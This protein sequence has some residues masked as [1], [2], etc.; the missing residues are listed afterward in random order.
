FSVAFAPDSRWALAGG[1]FPGLARWD[2]K[3]G[4][5]GKPLKDGT[6][7]GSRTICFAP[8]GKRVYAALEKN[9]CA[10]EGPAGKRLGSVAHPDVVSEVAI[11]PDGR[12]LV[13][14]CWDGQVRQFDLEPGG[15]IP[16]EPAKCY[17]WEI[18][19]LFAVAVSP[20]GILAAAGGDT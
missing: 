17:S 1:E 9:V 14:A 6:N 12:K 4:S 19:Q 10:W 18:G 15:A 8:D 11:S 2:L 20:D 16:D 5:P 7:S 13:T 3:D